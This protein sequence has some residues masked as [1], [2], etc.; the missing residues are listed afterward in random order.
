MCW[1]PVVFRFEESRSYFERQERE[2]F[3]I[4]DLIFPHRLGFY[5][6]HLWSL[7]LAG[8]SETKQEP[9]LQGKAQTGS[10]Q[11]LEYRPTD[12]GDLLAKA[13]LPKP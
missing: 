10:R 8:V 6:D 13:S 9:V 3:P 1:I 7:G 2:D 5:I 11:Y 12:L 4:S